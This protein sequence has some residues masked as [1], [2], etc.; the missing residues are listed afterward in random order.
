MAWSNPHSVGAGGMVR[1]VYP[2]QAQASIFILNT[3][4]RFSIIGA[5]ILAP[6]ECVLY[7]HIARWQARGMPPLWRSPGVAVRQRVGS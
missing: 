2:A 5:A 3:G 1:M 7:C 6:H 4:P